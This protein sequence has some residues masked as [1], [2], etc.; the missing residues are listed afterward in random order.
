MEQTKELSSYFLELI[1]KSN[2]KMPKNNITLGSLGLKGANRWQRNQAV[3]GQS[4]EA[5]TDK[6]LKIHC[7]YPKIVYNT[8]IQG[9]VAT[10]FDLKIKKGLTL[11]EIEIP[12]ILEDD[13]VKDKVETVKE[14]VLQAM[15]NAGRDEIKN[16][17]N[18]DL[19][20]NGDAKYFYGFDDEGKPYIENIPLENFFYTPEEDR[21]RSKKGT[22][23]LPTAGFLTTMTKF[24]FLNYIEELKESGEWELPKDIEEVMGKLCF[25]YTDSTEAERR[26][27]ATQINWREAEDKDIVQIAYICTLSCESDGEP[28]TYLLCGRQGLLIEQ[29]GEYPYK[30]MKGDACLPFSEE[31]ADEIRGRYHS[32][33]IDDI[34]DVSYATDQFL[35]SMMKRVYKSTDLKI[36]TRSR[37]I[38]DSITE[39]YNQAKESGGDVSVCTLDIDPADNDSRD[40][41]LNYF[42]SYEQLPQVAQEIVQINSMFSE[43]ADTKSG[44]YIHNMSDRNANF[45]TDVALKAENS[46]TAT[47][48][49]MMCNE[50]NGSFEDG[51]KQFIARFKTYLGNLKEDTIDLEGYSKELVDFASDDVSA[52]E[53]TDEGLPISQE[54]LKRDNAGYAQIKIK[55]ILDILD[56]CD[57]FVKTG[58]GMTT[59]K[60]NEFN[61]KLGYYTQMIS[62]FPVLQA[63]DVYMKMALEDLHSEAQIGVSKEDVR[64][65]FDEI[66]KQKEMQ[67]EQIKEEQNVQA[68]AQMG[69][70]REAV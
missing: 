46:E 57:V 60:T 8:I 1:N 49:I 39:Q 45:A 26:A 31:Y 27:E 68:M 38:Q 40:K 69:Q 14:I 43:L 37:E 36:M 64:R 18:S 44:I 24:A 52:L 25:D 10:D 61:R 13:N 41:P 35:N 47:K 62:S 51:D 12:Q 58:S 66:Q 54:F 2:D 33:P 22:A 67:E 29:K 70:S 32:S 6:N 4:T 19:V 3:L 34:I 53:K 16:E 65:V 23:K 17:G 7:G 63:S 11:G 15:E 50:K 28:H 5:Q 42:F 59:S 48:R 20:A 30:D 9:M 56:N 21:L 55:D